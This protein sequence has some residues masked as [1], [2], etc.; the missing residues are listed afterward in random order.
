MLLCALLGLKKICG[1]W[2]NLLEFG[3]H[4]IIMF[5]PMARSDAHDSW[6]NKRS[7]SPSRSRLFSTAP[8]QRSQQEAPRP[9]EQQQG[10]TEEEGEE[11]RKNEQQPGHTTSPFASLDPAP[12]SEDYILYTGTMRTR[13]ISHKRS[14][15][16]AQLSFSS[17]CQKRKLVSGSSQ[18]CRVL[19]FCYQK[20]VGVWIESTSSNLEGTKNV[21][22]PVVFPSQPQQIGQCA[23]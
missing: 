20:R 6:C 4:E 8:K 2:L 16:S 23:A 15:Q 10:D 9:P 13:S 19:S 21:P 12:H 7:F 22:H 11:Q 3:A 14:G 17:C 5:S 18:R 1:I